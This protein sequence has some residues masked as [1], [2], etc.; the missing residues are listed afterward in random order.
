MS[1]RRSLGWPITLGVVMIVLLVALMIGWVV[2]SILQ[3]TWSLLTVGTI[4]LVLVLV[5]VVLYLTIA[6]TQISLNQRQSNFI[7]SVT[8][9]LKS[10][11]AS[12]KLYL[13]T[14]SRRNVPEAQQADFYRFM[15]DD[16]DR[17][18]TLINHMLDAARLD[19]V[20]QEGELIDV[21]LAPLLESCAQTVCLQHRV[22]VETVTL[23]VAPTVVRGRPI[24]VEMVFRNLI[25]NA[26]KY[27]G[28][29]AKVTVDSWANGRGMVVTRVSD[30]GPGIPAKLRRK[31]FGRFVRLGNELERVQAGTGLGLFIVRT[32]VLRMRGKIAVRGRGPQPGTVFE[33][34]LPGHAAEPGVS[35]PPAARTTEIVEV[36]VAGEEVRLTPIEMRLLRYFIPS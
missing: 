22:P 30:S 32:L 33:V 14:L 5:G 1:R 23:D 11:I 17:L 28:P 25:D 9:E 8:H 6:V 15:L 34:E 16:L 2:L 13:Q 18:D 19:Q 27:S 10:P 35:P 24:D 29:Q 26:V 21:E 4:F 20:P 3:G 12:L 7:D 36:T 31:I